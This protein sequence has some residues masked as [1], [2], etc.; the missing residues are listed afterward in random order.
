[1]RGINTRKLKLAMALKSTSSGNK[2]HLEKIYPRHFIA[3][4]ETV[5]FC[6]VRMQEILEE[7]VDT[8]PSA[9]EQVVNQLPN[10]FPA[11]IIDS[12]VSNSLRILGKI[13]L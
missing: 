2:W 7:F 5:G 8:F 4:A 11:Q 3:T 12:I 1:G 9:I 6:T 10:G 13:K